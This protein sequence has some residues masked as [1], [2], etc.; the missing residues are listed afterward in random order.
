MP[1]QDHQ[2]RCYGDGSIRCALVIHRPP[3]SEYDAKTSTLISGNPFKLH[4]FITLPAASLSPCL[5]NLTCHGFMYVCMYVCIVNNSSV[6]FTYG[7][8]LPFLT[9]LPLL[10][11]LLQ[12]LSLMSPLPSAMSFFLF[13]SLHLTAVRP[14]WSSAIVSISIL[15]AL[16]NTA[17]NPSITH[18]QRAIKTSTKLHILPFFPILLSSSL[19]KR[20]INTNNTQP[21]RDPPHIQ[22]RKT[23]KKDTPDPA[24]YPL[25]KRA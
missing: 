6:N 9:A 15:N 17:F 20:K 19:P 4:L 14:R 10:L 16:P 1:D 25:A 21:S 11:L 8:P 3:L 2:S 13:F 18:Q 7:L 5:T 23:K 24:Q 22:I 12:L